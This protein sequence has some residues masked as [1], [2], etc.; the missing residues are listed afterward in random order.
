MQP[1]GT[2]TRNLWQSIDPLDRRILT[3]EFVVKL[4]GGTLSPV[5]FA[6]Y[7]SQ[8]ILYIRQDNEALELLAGRVFDEN[9]RAFFLTL[10]KDG[11]AVEKMLH[12]EY[13][14]YFKVREAHEQS[15]AFKAY[16]EFLL[17]HVCNSP[18]A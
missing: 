17:Q 14:A 11:L 16:G 6:H 12:D 18:F 1:K 2:F 7:L 10:A 15:P 13:L 5:S 8:D 3:C 9:I 4:A